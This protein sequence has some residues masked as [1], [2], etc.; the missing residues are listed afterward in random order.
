MKFD[1][2][3]TTRICTFCICGE[4]DGESEKARLNCC[5]S[6]SDATTRDILTRENSRK[7]QGATQKQP[8]NHVNLK[9][10]QRTRKSYGRPSIAQIEMRKSW[11][12]PRFLPMLRFF[13]TPARGIDDRNVKNEKKGTIS[14]KGC[15]LCR[16]PFSK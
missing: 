8:E 9:Q 7:E 15:L 1:S 6:K 5:N 10:N 4:K 13:P 3:A 2:I 12:M 11:K 14:G 16:V